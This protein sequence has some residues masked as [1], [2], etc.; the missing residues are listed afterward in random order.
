MLRLNIATKTVLL[1]T[2]IVAC[3]PIL[4]PSLKQNRILNITNIVD[5]VMLLTYNILKYHSSIAER[6]Q[7]PQMFNDIHFT[8]ICIVKFYLEQRKSQVEG[9][10]L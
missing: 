1:S 10:Q 5:K 3:P 7:V 8:A 6:I 9:I 2:N 4:I